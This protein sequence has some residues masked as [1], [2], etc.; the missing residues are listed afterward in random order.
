MSKLWGGRFTAETHPA[1]KKLNDS[2]N[3]DQRLW[4]E[5]I[6]GSIAH[7]TMLGEAGI[8]DNGDA[9]NI[10]DGLVAIQESLAEG[11]AELPADAEDIHAAI[12][13]MLIAAIGPVGKK[14]HTARSRNDQVATDIRLFV[15]SAIDEVV[16]ALLE[17]QSAIVEIVERE[18][19]TLMPG[20]TH[21]QR[22]QP[23]LLSHHLLAYFWMFERDKGRLKDGRKRVNISPLGSGA[24]A[25]TTFDIDRSRVAELLG[26]DG[27]SDNSMDAVSD[28]DF[29][30]EFLSSCALIGV[31]LSRLGEDIVLWNSQEFGYIE[32]DD[33]AA[34]G[35]SIMPQKKNPD[36][37]ELARGKSGRLIGNLVSMLTI[38]KGLPLTY[39][40]D[41][42]EDKEPLFD[43]VDTLVAVL[44]AVTAM[45]QTAK[46]NRERM[47]DALQNDFSIATDLADELVR[48]GHS[49]RDAH[50]IVGRLVSKALQQNIPLVQ[51]GKD[52][53]LLPAGFDLCPQASIDRR[54]GIGCCSLDSVEAQL[55]AA[56][57]V[58][59]S[60]PDNNN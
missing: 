59:T 57:S 1:V 2:F 28:R 31:H 46:F 49:F 17:L 34:T 33:C 37:A 48:S 50:E 27:V 14:L 44:P 21:L 13:T 45:L 25:G 55:L 29:I 10:V 56:Q 30:A 58:S 39:N 26:F 4:R 47:K 60:L 15:R 51:A 16:G 52:C 12:E 42:Q 11:S 35:S 7:A 41:L 54:K 19:G 53:G 18:K 20:Y 38:L 40:K 43:S 8:L 23:V 24:L 36:V 32:L 6:Q 3:F 22:A 5:D 9:S